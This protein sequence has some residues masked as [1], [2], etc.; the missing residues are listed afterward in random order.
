MENN[1]NLET[2]LPENQ[3]PSPKKKKRAG[4]VVAIIIAV[5]LLGI[6]VILGIQRLTFKPISI[7]VPSLPSVTQKTE[8]VKKFEGAQDFKAYL[9]K[10]AMLSDSSYYPSGAGLGGNLLREGMP[11]SE[12]AA[13][14]DLAKE[15]P[16]SG[17][18][19]E[20][21]VQVTGIDEPDIVKTD[22]KEIYYS[23][24]NRYYPLYSEG[25]E[26][27]PPYSEAKTRILRAFPPEDLAKKSEIDKTGNLLLDKDILIV[28]SEPNII[29]YNV[30]DPEKPEKKWELALENSTTLVAARLYQDKIYLVTRNQINGNEPCPIKPLSVNG[31][32][33]EFACGDIYHPSE[34]IPVDVTFMAMTIDPDSGKVEDKISFVG[35]SGSSVVYM[36]SGA[37]YVTYTYYSSVAGFLFDFYKNKASDLISE[38]ALKK[39]EKI[40]DYDLSERARLT[41]IE[42]ILANYAASL[43]P[44]ESLRIENET[45]NRMAA[46]QKEHQRELEKTGI[47]KM[48]LDKSLEVQAA[49]AVAGRPLNQFALDEYEGNLRIATTV[50]GRSGFMG[51]AESANDVYILDK[52]LEPKG[53]VQD[54]GISERIYAVRFIE[55]KGYVVTF[56]ETDPFYV[57][58]LSNPEKPVMAGELKIPG[59]S[60]YLHPI[61]K[62]KIL[63]IGEENGKVKISFFDVSTAA[64]PK[65]LDKYLLDE[66][67]SAILETHHAFLMDKKHNIFFLPGEKGGYIF[68]YRDEKL[69][70]VKAVSEFNVERAIYLDD[71]LYI[72]SGSKI[73]VLNETNWETVKELSF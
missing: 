51:Q 22:G 17:R 1:Q 62:D 29:G 49:G 6:M 15:T 31:V 44:D 50:G 24:T 2:L 20:T 10:G 73:T 70:L 8:E 12:A 45:T 5:F 16:S 39:L 30:A 58:D 36:S 28:F 40:K 18:V 4:K 43:A 65:E 71:Y 72:I 57:L 23:G 55:D 37:L 42:V 13:P 32:A 69:K 68:S 67:H 9:E 46:Y 61:T 41:E 53:Q 19:S 47:V 27:V 25:S 66:Y 3:K 52:K 33:L 7:L 14:T 56:K 63:G 60:G 48:G 34:I 26:S 64:N 59:Y 54:L 38:D 11:T 21:N 35:S